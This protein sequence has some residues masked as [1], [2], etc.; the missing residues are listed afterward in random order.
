MT[1]G[2]EFRLRLRGGQR[3]A[4]PERLSFSKNNSS[5]N[6]PGWEITPVMAVAA[7]TAGLAR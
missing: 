4:L 1:G 6:L 7:A 2:S 3:F 5:Y